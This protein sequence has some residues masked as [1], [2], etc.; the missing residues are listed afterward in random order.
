MERPK[1]VTEVQR[2]GGTSRARRRRR[3]I[4]M[5]ELQVAMVILASGLVALGSLWATHS[6]QVRQA[7]TWCVGEPNFY[8]APHA[9]KWMRLLKPP[10]ALDPAPPTPWLPEV[11]LPSPLPY[12]VQVL[13]QSADASQQVRTA[14]VLH[15]PQP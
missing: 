5:L 3:G 10:A 8:L 11:T 14:Q 7:E 15:T 13:T 9:D 2:S 1:Q 6:R 4:S 12:H